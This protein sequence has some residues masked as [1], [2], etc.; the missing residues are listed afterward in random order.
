MLRAL[1]L[2]FA[3]ALAPAAALAQDA[4][5]PAGQVQSP[6]LTIDVDRL[7]AETRFGQRLAADLQARL[8]TLREENE[9][10]FDTLRAEELAL[11]EQRPSMDVDAFRAAAEDFDARAERIR[12]EQDAKEEALNASLDQD[13]RAFQDAVRPVLGRLMIESGAAVILERRDV[14]LIASPV[15]ITDEAIAAI[16]AELGDG[17]TVSGPATT[18]APPLADQES[19]PALLSPEAAAEPPAGEDG[20]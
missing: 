20:G 19:G 5:P 17:S 13:R 14:L 8:A 4:G 10:L 3:M 15:D 7:L 2:P 11:A 6:I 9:R 1:I 18:E 12:A 16:D